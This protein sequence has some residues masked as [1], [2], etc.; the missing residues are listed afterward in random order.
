MFAVFATWY[1][2]DLK[3]KKFRILG[4]AKIISALLY[5][6]SFVAN[7]G[8]G[9]SILAWL[10]RDLILFVLLMSSFELFLKYKSFK[11]FTALVLL[12]TGG[13]KLYVQNKP[14]L[15]VAETEYNYNKNAELIVNIKDTEQLKEIS[16]IIAPYQGTLKQAFPQ[17]SDKDITDLDNC[18]TIDIPN[19]ELQDE[20]ANKLRESPLVEWVEINETYNLSPSEKSSGSSSNSN[21]KSNWKDFNDPLLKNAWAFKYL[22]V[23]KLSAKLKKTKPKKK[24]KIFI[25]D[26]GVDAQH[27]DIKGNYTS[28]SDKYDRDTHTHGTHCAGIA[29]AVSNNGIGVA[30]LN[31]NGKF[32]T[33][34]SITVLPNGSGTQESIIDGMILAADNGADVISMS[35]GGRSSDQRQKAYNEAIEYANKKGAIVVVAAGNEGQ[36]A[37][38]SVPASCKNV[39]TVSAVADELVMA[40]F[41]NF[42][43]DLE[44]KIAGPGVEILS[45]VPN[46][47][48][49]SMSGTSMATP[50]VAGLVG[51]MKSLDPDLTT[52][53]VYNILNDTGLDT[54]DTEKT[55]KFL[56]PNNAINQIDTSSSWMDSLWKWIWGWLFNFSYNSH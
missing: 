48:Y 50:Y 15:N 10:G 39:I 6:A 9:L 12:G 34:T 52:K 38:T 51:I 43:T 2:L 18:Y 53:E 54:N 26:T 14:A 5:L 28:I 19:K 8:F 42:V 31:T 32:A 37:T 40:K 17:L 33:V 44:F 25:L 3:G 29:N 27:E 30:S 55:G 24:A 21:T 20:L 22:E 7:Y 13:Y 45:T 56:Q 47:K 23:N 4:Y 36:N 41:S 49:E 46:N 11:V 16:N 1:A 35:L